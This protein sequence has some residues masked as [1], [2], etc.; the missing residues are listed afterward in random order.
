MQKITWRKTKIGEDGEPVV[1]EDGKDVVATYHGVH[2]YAVVKRGK[3]FL[4]IL[5]NDARV[6]EVP[7]DEIIP[8]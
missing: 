4:V 5:C 2:L 6:R 7:I 3:T 8:Y 1:D